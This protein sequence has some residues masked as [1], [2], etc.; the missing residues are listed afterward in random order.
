MLRT[1]RETES[2]LIGS[3]LLAARRFFASAIKLVF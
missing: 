1:T 3:H 2:C